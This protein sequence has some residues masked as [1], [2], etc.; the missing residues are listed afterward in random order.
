MSTNRTIKEL[1]EKCDELGLVSAGTAKKD[2]ID[3]LSN[4][5]L[6]EKIIS[7]DPYIKHLEMVMKIESPMLCQRYNVLSEKEQ[8]DIWESDDW[9]VEEKEDGVRMLIVCIDGVLDFY[10]RNISSVD[11][12]PISYR[13]N[14]PNTWGDNFKGQT[15]ILDAEVISNSSSVQTRTK[16]NSKLQAVTA[17]L[18]ID[19]DESIKIQEKENY[20]LEFKVFDMLCVEHVWITH[21]PLHSRLYALQLKLERCKNFGLKLSM[22]LMAYENKK[23]FYDNLI[24][25]GKEGCVAKNIYSPYNIKGQRKRDG[26]IKIKRNMTDS[27]KQQGLGDTIDAFISG[28]EVGKSGKKWENKVGSLIFSINLYDEKTIKVHEIATISGFSDELRDSITEIKDGKP[29]LKENF[30][31]KV[32]S[33]NGQCVS[34]KGMKLKHAVIVDW[35]PDRSEDTCVIDLDLIKSM[36]L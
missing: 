2:Y 4:Y 35:R 19:G 1:Q 13:K 10:S 28:Y 26:F 30:Y 27:M 9:Y 18:S 11:F 16:T 24:L 12:L 31:G 36:I 17:L 23:E 14:I 34:S 8:N 21:H 32:A 29:C 5:Y 3:V 22:P 6:E 7:G 33:I 20:P 15:F 25:M